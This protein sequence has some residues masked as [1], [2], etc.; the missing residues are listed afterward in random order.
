MTIWDWADKHPWMF[1]LLVAAALL[2]IPTFSIRW[3][4]KKD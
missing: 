2:S 1:L 3:Y 4:R